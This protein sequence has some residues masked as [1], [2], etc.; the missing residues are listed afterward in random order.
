MKIF[1]KAAVVAA[2]AIAAAAG[3]ASA[4]Q[5][6]DEPVARGWDHAS[7]PIVVPTGWDHT[8]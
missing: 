5:Q 4:A 7:A 8:L 1:A 2:L 3:P 6:G